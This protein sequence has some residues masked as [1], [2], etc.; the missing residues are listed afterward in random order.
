MTIT[1]IGPRVLIKPYKQDEKTKGGIYIPESAKE[2]KK[3]G[4]VVAV[5]TFE[6]GK[7]LPLKA[8]DK[9]L[10]GGYSQEEVE[11]DKE[12]YVIVEF[13]NIVAKFD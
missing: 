9:V 6:D 7:A 10:Y 1:P 2:K 8:G 4:D 13:K 12:D 3:Q 5:G 11:L